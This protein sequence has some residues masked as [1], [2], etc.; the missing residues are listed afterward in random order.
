MSHS[1]FVAYHHLGRDEEGIA[2]L[3]RSLAIWQAQG[4]LGGQAATHRLPA[5]A[6]DNTGR[7]PQA[8]GEY[9]QA[10]ALSWECGD[11]S[12]EGRALNNM[13]WMFQHVA[14][15]ERALGFYRAAYAIAISL[16]EPALAGTVQANMAGLYLELGRTDD[17]IA[18]A[19]T[20][21][22]LNERC[23]HWVELAN[24][25]FALGDA[26]QNL[27]QDADAREHWQAALDGYQVLGDARAAEV[28]TRL[29]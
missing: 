2:D 26:F 16:P 29:G 8:I 22:E 12:G 5:A 18:A 15:P 23:G 11:R 27:G 25:H 13:G 7:V 20:A 21:I 28:V 14:E 9:E 1:L 19:T 24:A 4:D 6:Y 10:I 3:R 17:A